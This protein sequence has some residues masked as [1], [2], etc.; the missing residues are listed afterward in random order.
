[1]AHHVA[2]WVGAGMLTVGISS[3]GLFG[4]SI[5]AA[6]TAD[7]TE[8]GDTPSSQSSESAAGPIEASPRSKRQDKESNSGVP[9][10]APQSDAADDDDVVSESEL[11]SGV[12][13]EITD[14]AG[15]ADADTSDDERGDGD[16]PNDDVRTD[17][18]T[19]GAVEPNRQESTS[20]KSGRLATP[21]VVPP[22]VEPTRITDGAVS[23]TAGP[24][25]VG[26]DSAMPVAT[27]S[28]SADADAQLWQP[29]RPTLI[30]VVGS[31]FFGLLDAA[32][33]AIVGPAAVPANST[34]RVGRSALQIDC[35]DGYTAE[36]DWY[37]PTDQQPP[38]GLIYLQHGFAS[39]PGFYNATAADLADAT[40]SVVVVP[41]ITSNFFACDACHLTGDPMHFAVAKLFSGERGAL[42]TSLAAAFPGEDITLPQRYVLTGHSGGSSFAA[43]V[44]GFASQLG[45][46]GGTPDLA[47]VILFDTN[48]IGDFVSRG[49]AKVPGS[50][51]VYYVGA[52]P[53]LINN[54]DQVSGVMQ[55]LRPGTFIGVR[56]L[57]GVHTDAMDSTNGFVE[58]VA[59]L[60]LGTP[61][62]ANMA[63]TKILAAGWI[64]D[65]FSAGPDTGLYPG[66]G[67]TVGLDTAAGTATLGDLRGP[68]YEPSS[69]EALISRFY[70]LINNLRFGYCA[71]DV[72]ALL[73]AELGSSTVGRRTECDA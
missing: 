2:R 19:Q 67:A 42:R 22:A 46:A 28:A 71:A 63:A 51:P 44:A 21:A 70:G 3:A 37:V 13:A 40:N 11:A 31:I 1:M 50:T 7:S 12:P 20:G 5:A 58:F 10:A 66:V 55:A 36:A 61:K 23:P 56:L 48:D 18:E 38:Q 45:G 59:H 25:A 62:P 26:A 73:A 32:S 29:T 65:M 64:N 69:F 47:G 17:P 49:V 34:V 52:G 41:F 9:G 4:A 33:A 39:R 72:D 16:T 30:N 14:T 54:F 53:A 8:T 24:T 60:V 6:D 43:G 57:D 68:L 35:G 27:A 15:A